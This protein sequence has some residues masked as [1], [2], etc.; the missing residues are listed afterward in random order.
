MWKLT[1]SFVEPRPA[2]LW[3]Q[4]YMNRKPRTNCSKC[5]DVRKQPQVAVRS[6]SLPVTFRLALTTGD[7]RVSS[8]LDELHCTVTPVAPV[9]ACHRVYGSSTKC[10]DFLQRL[11]NLK[12]RECLSLLSRTTK[13]IEG[14]VIRVCVTLQPLDYWSPNTCIVVLLTHGRRK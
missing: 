1:L 13:K 4:V 3:Y 7:I 2:A 14:V 12:C 5:N 11:T 6:L 10:I 9:T 8:H